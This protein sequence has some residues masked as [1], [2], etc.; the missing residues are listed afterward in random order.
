MSGQKK[1]KLEVFT[2]TLPS[3]KRRAVIIEYEVTKKEIH[4]YFVDL[5]EDK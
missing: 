5:K 4:R 3:G 2:Q 1:T